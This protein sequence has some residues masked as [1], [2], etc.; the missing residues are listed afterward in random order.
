MLLSAAMFGGSPLLQLLGT[1]G[2]RTFFDSVSNNYAGS[3]SA[4][5]TKLQFN[6]WKIIWNNN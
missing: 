1:N 4:Q 3:I 6:L 5:N 2:F